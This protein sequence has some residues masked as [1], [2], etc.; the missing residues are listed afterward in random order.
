MKIDLEIIEKLLFESSYTAWDIEKE[1]GLSRMMVTN[2]RNKKSDYMNMKLS[3]AVKLIDYYIK[4]ENEK[5]EIEMEDKKMIEEYLESYG[6]ND[7]NERD[8]KLP[9]TKQDASH[10]SRKYQQG[11]VYLYT[12][13]EYIEFLQDI[14]NDMIEN[15]KAQG[16]SEED[17]EDAIEDNVKN[18][19]WIKESKCTVFIEQS[20]VDDYIS[21]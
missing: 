18:L 10:L 5:D 16:A 17:V 20:G 7:S 14:I 12:K 1:T 2:Y 13:K 19:N 3:N 15:E 8:N 11:D 6:F 21:Y 9:M 4:K